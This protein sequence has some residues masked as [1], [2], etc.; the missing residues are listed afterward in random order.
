MLLFDDNCLYFDIPA[1]RLPIGKKSYILVE[2]AIKSRAKMKL[3]LDM[4]G[5]M[6]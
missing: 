3:F 2:R 4:V 1:D 6:N 5:G